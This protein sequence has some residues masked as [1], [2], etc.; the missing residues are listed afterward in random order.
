[1]IN[2]I[3]YFEGNVI[4]KVNQKICIFLLQKSNLKLSS[5]FL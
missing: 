5:D 2:M 1:M 4:V 3:I